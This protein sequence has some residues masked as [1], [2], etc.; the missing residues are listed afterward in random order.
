MKMD[1]RKQKCYGYSQD[2][3]VQRLGPGP[4]PKIQFEQSATIRNEMA[5]LRNRV[6]LSSPISAVAFRHSRVIVI[7][8]I[9]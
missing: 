1:D 5:D 4:L 7:T 2:F 9:I 8:W 6:T 3:I